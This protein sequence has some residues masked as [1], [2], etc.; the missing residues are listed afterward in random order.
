VSRPA[1]TDKIMEKVEFDPF[2]GCWLWSGSLSTRGY[3][4]IVIRARRYTLHRVLYEA[5]KGPIPVGLELDHLCRVR[6]C[7]NP[8]H[9]EPVTHK[10]NIER[11]K[12]I[13][14]ANAAKTHCVHGHPLSGENLGLTPK[15]ARYCRTCLRER[16]HARYAKPRITEEENRR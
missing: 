7:L 13:T 2:G 8:A 15:G 4:R 16:G 11:G 10:E 3:G 14:V 5:L 9:L 6:C 12:S 1:I